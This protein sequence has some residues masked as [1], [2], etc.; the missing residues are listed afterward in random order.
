MKGRVGIWRSW[1]VNFVA[2][3]TTRLFSG[4]FLFL[5]FWA[6]IV[7]PLSPKSIIYFLLR[8]R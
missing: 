2:S 7:L 8:G 1:I 3:V 4:I 6:P 5:S